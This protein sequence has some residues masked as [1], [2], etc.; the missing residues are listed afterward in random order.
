MYSAGVQSRLSWLLLQI[1]DV[2]LLQ[3]NSLVV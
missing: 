1:V 3:H 2:L